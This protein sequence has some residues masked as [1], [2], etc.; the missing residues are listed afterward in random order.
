[1]DCTSAATHLLPEPSSDFD[2]RHHGHAWPQHVIVIWRLINHDLD[3]YAL[4]DLDIIARGVFRW[5]QTERRTR[6]RLNA[7]H[8]S[9][10][11]LVRVGIHAD[12]RRLSRAHVP[13]L[14]LLEV[15]HDPYLI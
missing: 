2:F 4:H 3:R 15:R 7:V 6:A 14:R 1:M 9:P 8:V 13:K 10:E 12:T 11:D 5:Q